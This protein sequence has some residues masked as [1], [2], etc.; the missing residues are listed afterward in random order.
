MLCYV[1]LICWW[2]ENGSQRNKIKGTACLHGERSTSLV[3]FEMVMSVYVVL[4]LSVSLLTSAT[5]HQTAAIS[6]ARRFV[7]GAAERA[8]DAFAC[9][10]R[11]VIRRLIHVHQVF[12]RG[13]VV[14]TV[15]NLQLAAFVYLDFGR[16]VVL[17]FEKISNLLKFLDLD[18]SERTNRISLI[19]N[20]YNVLM[21]FYVD[22]CSVNPVNITIIIV[23]VRGTTDSIMYVRALTNTIMWTHEMDV[24]LILY[25]SK[26]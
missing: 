19:C 20:I 21:Y 14:T 22:I 7:T 17:I 18:V 11:T 24:Y 12:G 13:Q 9:V 3:F 15:L 10:V 16:A 4:W 23:V 5:A 6:A 26:N 25:A 8:R 2:R 1:T